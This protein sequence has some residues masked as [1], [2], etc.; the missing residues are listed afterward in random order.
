MITPDEIKALALLYDRYAN[1]IDPFAEDRDRAEHAFG[2]LL[3]QLY[4]CRGDGIEFHEF[5]RKAVTLCRAYLRNPK[6]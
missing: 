5:R 4:C 3:E 1:A 6:N 2:Q